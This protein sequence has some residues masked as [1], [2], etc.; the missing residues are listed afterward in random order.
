MEAM[1]FCYSVLYCIFGFLGGIVYPYAKTGVPGTKVLGI[2]RVA[3][4]DI[5]VDCAYGLA[6]CTSLARYWIVFAEWLFTEKLN[7]PS[8]GI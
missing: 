1:Y 3:A 2:E 7:A 8:L 5:L 6:K 4:R